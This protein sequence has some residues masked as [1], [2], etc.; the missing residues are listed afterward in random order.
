MLSV[1]QGQSSIQFNTVFFQMA[2]VL[3]V[4]ARKLWIQGAIYPQSK[5]WGSGLPQVRFAS[6]SVCAIGCI[7][8]LIASTNI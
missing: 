3:T 4:L 1:L 7:L 8:G 2:G 6:V 5:L